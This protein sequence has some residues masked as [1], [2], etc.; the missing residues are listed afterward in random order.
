MRFIGFS[1]FDAD[2][3]R[4]RLRLWRW[5]TCRRSQCASGTIRTFAIRKCPRSGNSSCV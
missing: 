3:G 4:S 5:T 2:F 1:V